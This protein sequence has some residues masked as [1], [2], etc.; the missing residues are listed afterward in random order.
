MLWD[1]RKLFACARK[2][3][4]RPKYVDI[5]CEGKMSNAVNTESAPPAK[6]DQLGHVEPKIEKHGHDVDEAMR[7]FEALQGETIELD[8]ATNRR[9]LRTVDWHIMPIMCFVY[10][11]NYL[12][13]A[14]RPISCRFTTS[15][16][17][18]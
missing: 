1:I 14:K 5:L 4:V 6:T 11:M 7:A 17:S 12:D 3:P 8:E 18:N 10:G 13:S 16:T 9:L 15:E 2:P